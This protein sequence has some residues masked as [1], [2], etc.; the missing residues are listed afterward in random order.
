MS[1]YANAVKDY[2]EALSAKGRRR[3]D[4]P[5]CRRRM[6]VSAWAAQA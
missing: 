5:A 2:I 3:T 4:R 1:A 6:G